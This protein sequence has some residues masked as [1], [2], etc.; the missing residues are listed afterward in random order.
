MT[1]A[2]LLLAVG[3]SSLSSLLP[4]WV[5]LPVGVERWLWNP[6]ERTAAA[7]AAQGRGEPERALAPLA[8]AA[9]LQPDDPLVQFNAG[10]GQLL[11][12]EADAA[13]E[14]LERAAET[15]PADLQPAAHYNLGTARL[16]AND[17]AGAVESLSASL[18]LDPAQPDAKHN[19]ELALRALEE[20][21]RRR[22]Q[23]SPEGAPGEEPP[24]NQPRQDSGEPQP[25]PSGAERDEQQQDGQTPPPDPDQ[26]QPQGEPQPGDEPPQ[27]RPGRGQGPLPQF[28]DVPDMTAEQAAALLEAVE[29][30]ERQ[31]RRQAAAQRARR[32]PAAG[33]DW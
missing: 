22:P 5:H 31:Q 23:P 26:G 11:A 3:L 30:L 25:D 24:R 2:T 21:R 14:P 28:R 29:N 12:G 32:R 6:R 4:S 33:A 19:L 27:E 20:E 10:S 7:I 8:T 9:R 16:Q 15:A 18:R 17:P 13:L 1:A